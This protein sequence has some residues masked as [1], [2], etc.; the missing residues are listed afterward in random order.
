MGF[1]KDDAPRLYEQKDDWLGINSGGKV[2]CT[3]RG[4]D[5]HIQIAS[6][7]LFE[8]CR[9]EHGWRDYPCHYENCSFVAYCSN[10][11]KQ[12]S[13]QFHTVR[14]SKHYDFRCSKKNC[15][16]GFLRRSLLKDH[17]NI[18]DNVQRKCI[19]C[20]YTCVRSQTLSMHQRA[21]F[22]IRNYKCEICEMEFLNT[23]H[24]NNHF[25]RKQSG[26]KVDCPLCDFQAPR[27]TVQ[28]HLVNKHGIMGSHWSTEQQK[29]ILPGFKTTSK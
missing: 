25:D 7:K 13:S 28:V 21:H 19:F 6:N 26:N 9:L 23:A 18:H 20:P 29:F 4:C 5:F 10:T 12:H 11:F 14:A 24:L 2:L 8:H 27:F 15:Q 3:H 22:N 17:E 16:A 1:D